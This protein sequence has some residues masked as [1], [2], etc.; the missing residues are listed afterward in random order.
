MKTT[1][2]VMAFI[3]VAGLI[4]C[5]DDEDA[6][7]STGSGGNGGAGGSATG[8]V[9]DVLAL[10]GDATAGATVFNSSCGQS[11]CHGAD[12]TASTTNA[13]D[14]TTFASTISDARLIQ[15]IIDGS[16]GQNVMPPLGG[17]FSDQ[18]IADVVAYV[19]ATFP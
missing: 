13:R 17:Q 2:V 9:A 18:E 11:N 15:V 19:R 4:G 12:G 16:V 14:L 7:G 6:T 10:T 1:M 3:A 8:R 5:G